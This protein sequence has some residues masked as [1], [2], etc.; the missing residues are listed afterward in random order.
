MTN[1][2][3]LY[4]VDNLGALVYGQPDDNRSDAFVKRGPGLDP[5]RTVEQPDVKRQTQRGIKSATREIESELAGEIVSKARNVRDQ[6]DDKRRAGIVS[7]LEVL[8]D[9]RRAL[10][11][12]L[13]ELVI[14]TQLLTDAVAVFRAMA[15]TGQG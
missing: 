12:E 3:L 2:Y 9:E 1:G 7:Q 6:T 8:E 5:L 14:Q 4:T 11:A 10:A 15:T 13:S